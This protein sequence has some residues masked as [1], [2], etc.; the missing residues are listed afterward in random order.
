M[1]RSPLSTVVERANL[2][3]IVALRK[4]NRALEQELARLRAEAE[5]RPLANGVAHER[6]SADVVAAHEA[7]LAELRADHERRHES[8]RQAQDALEDKLAVAPRRAQAQGRRMRR[9]RQAAR[10]ARHLE[11]KLSMTTEALEASQ[12]ELAAMAKAAP[13]LQTRPPPRPPRP[14]PK[15]P[16]K[17]GGGRAA[18]AAH[19]PRAA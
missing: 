2:Q 18:P 7:E 17:Q 11:H 6:P 9:E 5:P 16:P 12:S 10:T 1:E 15:S 4:A 8:M 14:P 19:Q 3:K 13:P